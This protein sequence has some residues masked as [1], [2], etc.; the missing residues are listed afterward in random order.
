[1]VGS[2]PTVSTMEDLIS[3]KQF[4][5]VKISAKDAA[6]LNKLWHSRLPDIPWTNIVRN[7]CYVCYAAVYNSKFFAVGIWSS[8]VARS[9][10]GNKVLELRRFAICSEAPKY[11]ATWMLG[12]MIKLIRKEFPQIKRLLSYQD[13]G[14]HSGTIYKAGNWVTTHIS[15]LPNWNRLRDRKEP[16]YRTQKIRWEYFL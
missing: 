14:V 7:K 12:K 10:D 11:T 2:I 8:P 4:N 3:P 13:T 15:R 5:I 9:F 1:M 6:D 16:K